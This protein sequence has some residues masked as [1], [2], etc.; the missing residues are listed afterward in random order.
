MIASVLAMI[1]AVSTVV[2]A[3]GWLIQKAS[4]IALVKYLHDKNYTPPTDEETATC[5]RYAWGQILRRR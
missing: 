5:L 1:F 2:C 3:M 4:C